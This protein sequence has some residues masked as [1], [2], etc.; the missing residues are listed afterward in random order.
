MVK[1]ILDEGKCRGCG[2]CVDICSLEL[3]EI[4]DTPDGKKIAMVIEEASEI[5]HTCMACRDACPEEAITVI[6]EEE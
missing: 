2:K 4:E 1:H 6:R 3:W 5:C